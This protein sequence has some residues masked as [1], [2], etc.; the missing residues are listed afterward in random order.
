MKKTYKI[1]GTK[2]PVLSTAVLTYPI[3]AAS[4][5]EFGIQSER[6]TGLN[7]FFTNEKKREIIDFLGWENCFIYFEYDRHYENILKNWFLGDDILLFDELMIL[8]EKP[9]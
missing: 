9:F 4:I 6:N 8:L 5:A 3:G 1:S 7:I 2:F